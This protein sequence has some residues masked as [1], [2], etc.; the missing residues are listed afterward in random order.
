MMT[1]MGLS[2][3]LLFCIS[4]FR[5]LL[6]RCLTL[7]E[8]KLMDEYGLISERDDLYDI[9]NLGA[10]LFAKQLKDFPTLRGKEIIVRRYQGT[11]NRIL[12]L[13]ETPCL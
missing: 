1:I 12:S 11:N 13:D 7:C 3:N 4:R 2:V 6:T 8:A 5:D 10:I 9:L